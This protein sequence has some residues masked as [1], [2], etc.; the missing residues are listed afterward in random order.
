MMPRPSRR[1]SSATATR[2]LTSQLVTF[3][4]TPDG[5]VAVARNH[6]ELIAGG[7]AA[8]LEGRIEP[9]ARLLGCCATGS[10][11]GLALTMM[12]WLLSGGTLLL[13]HGFDAGAFAA[14]CRERWPRY[15]GRAGRAGAAT[16]G[17]RIAGSR[18]IEERAR[19]LAR[20]GALPRQPGLAALRA[21]SLTDMHIFGEIGAA[22]L[23]PRRRRSCRSRCRC[24]RSWRRAARPTPCRSPTSP[25][26]R[27]HACAARADGAAPSRSRP[28]P[29]ASARR[30][31][32]PI[33][34]GFV[35]TFYPCRLDRMIRHGHGDRPAAGRRQ[36]RLL[37]LRAART[38]GPGAARGRRRFRHRVARCAGRTPPRRHFRR[39]RRHARDARRAW[40]S[41][42][43][44]PTLFGAA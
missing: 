13:H 3:D 38:G 10:F 2:R 18:R 15:R 20:A 26:P 40:R 22:R 28:A 29:N 44:L 24:T 1:R 8:L 25:A 17:G 27:R 34:E 21:P 42:R 6:A 43:S 4:V 32:R 7:L 37:S 14:Q 12:P 11:A 33:A 16:G 36:R 41:I 19:G 39:R 9:D 30:T 31:S 23:A 35:D 5:L